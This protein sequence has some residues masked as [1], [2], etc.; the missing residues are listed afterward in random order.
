MILRTL[1]QL[2]RERQRL[3]K[4]LKRVN[5]NSEKNDEI[6]IIYVVFFPVS[7]KTKDDVTT[8]EDTAKKEEP[9]PVQQ[10][11]QQQSRWS[12]WG[13]A[14]SMISNASKSV[15][16][17]TTQVSQSITSAIENSIN[18]PEPEEMAKIHAEDRKMSKQS[19]SSEN[20][21]ADEKPTTDDR[22][23]KLDSIVSGVSQMSSKLVS[24]GLDTLEGIGKKTITILQESNPDIKNKIRGINNQQNLSD[25]LKEAKDRSD[26]NSANPKESDSNTIKQ[27]SFDI[28]FEDF[29]GT[30]FLE[31]LGILANQ[32]KM[33]IDMVMK[34]LDGKALKEI[35]ETL[36][37]VKELCELPDIEVGDDDIAIDQMEEKLKSLV[38]DLNIQLNFKE[39]ISCLLKIKEWLDNLDKDATGQSIYT[40]SIE[41]LANVCALS[42]GTLHKL[43]ELLL[44][45]D[46]R[47]TSDESDSVTQ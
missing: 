34:P 38:E 35:E 11:E 21:A 2:M 41:S 12:P 45:L 7:N 20:P 24:G 18:I 10:E 42:L 9:V 29:K 43:A 44:S 26:E 16:S 19:D 4:K 22:T 25:I 46:H 27:V 3:N 6:K 39:L 8:K 28:L 14:F 13:G 33:K 47:S 37:E 30:V 40:K 5:I 23:F 31:A 17:I 1:N 15:A 36:A 32:S